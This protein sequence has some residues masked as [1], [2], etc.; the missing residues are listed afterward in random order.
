MTTDH[1][2]FPGNSRTGRQ[3]ISGEKSEVKK[4][5]IQSVV[6]GTVVTKK[7]SGW[8][9]LKEKI[10]SGADNR[11]V[12]DYVFHDILV[13][14]GRDILFDAA[15]AGLER[16]IYGEVLSGGRRGY[17]R[18][19]RTAYHSI[20][21][22]I[23][24]EE[25]RH[26]REVGGGGGRRVSRSSRDL[27][28]VIVAS[29]AEAADVIDGLFEVLSRYGVA[30][31]ADLCDLIGQSHSFTDNDW[32]WLDLRGSDIE[33]VRDGYLLVLPRVQPLD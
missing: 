10:F 14:A 20:H 32:G 22:N 17:S 28:D 8:R 5:K 4:E 33:R 31:V 2:E 16:K 27:E 24:R 23:F 11:S 25:P 26:S 18:G 15:N 9:R 12:L 30:T 1:N 7:K 21:G 13:P 3:D 6:T 29:R 19:G